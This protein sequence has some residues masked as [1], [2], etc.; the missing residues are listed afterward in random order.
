MT[1][2]QNSDR[3]AFSPDDEGI[4]MTFLSLVGMDYQYV[5][6][7][8]EAADRLAQVLLERPNANDR[9]IFPMCFMFRHY[10]ELQCKY[11]IEAVWH[12]NSDEPFKAK[13][14]HSL[15]EL[16]DDTRKVVAPEFPD[17]TNVPF[18]SVQSIIYQIHDA[19][20]TGQEFR[21]ARTTRGTPS[22]QKIPASFNMQKLYDSMQRAETFLAQWTF[23]LDARFDNE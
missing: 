6:S 13:F 18:D 20:P 12:L 3:T 11:L 8:Y 14:G 1:D 17:F 7:F 23:E 21:Y 5:R 19:D 10:L 2:Q 9:F 15:K 22:L 4:S 16:W